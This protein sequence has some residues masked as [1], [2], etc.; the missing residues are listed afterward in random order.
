M[1]RVMAAVLLFALLFVSTSCMSAEEREARKEALSALN[2]ASDGAYSLST[3]TTIE[4]QNLYDDQGI[5]IQLAGIQGPP[6]QPVL[7]LAVKN[8]SRRDITLDVDQL[9]INGWQVDGWCDLYQVESHSIT[10][11]TIEC[12]SDLSFC[13]VSDVGQVD[14]DFS[15]RDADTYEDLAAVCTSFSTSA[16][17]SLDL[18][19]PPDGITLLEGSDFL[20]RAVSFSSSVYN[21]TWLCLY[22]ENNSLLGLFLEASH[23]RLNGQPIE[24]WFWDS[25]APGSRRILTEYLYDEDTYDDILLEPGDVLTFDLSICDYDTGAVLATQNISLSPEDF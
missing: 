16:A 5:I 10:I 14:L 17:D 2:G 21:G 19:S 11:G 18:A 25:T 15:I 23:A 9:S 7:V 20:V 4:N 6:A 24:L 22:L 12:S 3:G 13:G 8:G 1:K